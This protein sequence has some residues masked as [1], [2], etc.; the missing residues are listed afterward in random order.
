MNTNR[1]KQDHRG[2]TNEDHQ[3]AHTKWRNVQSIFKKMFPNLKNATVDKKYNPM[4]YQSKTPNQ[5]FETILSD[6]KK[7]NNSHK[8]ERV[9]NPAQLLENSIKTNKPVNHNNNKAQLLENSI[10]ASI[11]TA[12][13]IEKN[14]TIKTIVKAFVFPQDV[15]TSKHAYEKTITNKLTLD[16]MTPRF[17][18][19][20]CLLLRG[21]KDTKVT[22]TVRRT[23]FSSNKETKTVYQWFI[24]G[25]SNLSV[26]PNIHSPLM[27]KKHT[28]FKHKSKNLSGGGKKKYIK[29][30]SGGKRLIRYGLRGGKYYV[31]DG[32]KI[33]I[34]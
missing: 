18:R 25:L 22:L 4:Y 3:R 17:N 19:I 6:F 31:K 2:W 12:V 13:N 30:Q 24:Q 29:L 11:N 20:V 21:K 15:T 10:R 14:A 1:V 16:N 28:I 34:K 5:I 9:N 8:P 7:P 23:R 27:E 33:Y 32:N 26:L